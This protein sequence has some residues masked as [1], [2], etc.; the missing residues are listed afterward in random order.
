VTLP[1]KGHPLSVTVAD[2]RA[3]RQLDFTL[4]HEEAVSMQARFNFSDNKTNQIVRSLR[5]SGLSVEPKLRQALVAKGKALNDFFVSEIIPQI[6]KDAKTGLVTTVQKVAIVCND[7]NGLVDYLIEK[8]EVGPKR[9]V[10]IGADG[11]GG[12]LKICLNLIDMTPPKSPTASP[13]AK[14][15]SV[16]KDSGVKKLIVLAIMQDTQERYENIKEILGVLHLKDIDFSVAADMKLINIVIGI[17]SYGSTY[18]CAWCESTGTLTTDG[19]ERTLGRI[20]QQ[21]AAYRNAGSILKSAKSFY[22]CIHPPLIAGDN[23]DTILSKIPP[24]ELHIM[25][26]VTNKI[27]DELNR[28]W[29]ENKAYKWAEERSIVRAHYHGGCLDGNSCKKLL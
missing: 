19:Q 9:L 22:N 13:E 11:G 21:V 24:P 16:F 6:H 5:R 17:Q 25:L 1:T 10:R 4:S 8:R 20:R 7:V 14:K 18:P 23:S 29:E 28:K 15:Q 2:P 26:G 3:K 12:F 27:F